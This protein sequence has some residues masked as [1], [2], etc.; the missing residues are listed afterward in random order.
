[1]MEASLAKHRGRF[2]LLLLIGLLGINFSLRLMAAL[3]PLKFIDG[4]M[5]P[6][7]AYLSLTL[8]RNIAHGLGPLYGTEFTNGFQPL[9]VFLA[10]PFYWIWR[11]NPVAPVH[12]AL[13]MLAVFDTLALWLLY[14]LV[15]L[16]T[17]SRLVPPLVGAAW[18]FN[19][20]VIRTSLNGMETII[21]FALIL[22]VFLFFYR[23]FWF[24][25]EKHR[26]RHDLILG[27]LLGLAVFARIDSV[28]WFRLFWGRWRCSTSSGAAA[29]ANISSPWESSV[30]VRRRLSSPGCFILITIRAR[31]FR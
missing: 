20:Y 23:Y 26:S 31:Y 2:E 6:D 11:S 21:A 30:S 5:I 10:A 1:M 4:I 29:G 8:A 14:R 3:R 15:G 28:F 18:I 12:A 7:D 9:Y 24:N 22:A 25:P 27:L 13:I 17:R 16:L 19:P